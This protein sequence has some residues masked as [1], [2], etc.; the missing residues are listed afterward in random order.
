MDSYTDGM[1][2][3]PLFLGWSNVPFDLSHIL[4]QQDKAFGLSMKLAEENKARAQKVKD[5]KMPDIT[6][7]A[8]S[9]AYDQQALIQARETL[10]S[11]LESSPNPN[12][13]MKNSQAAKDAARVLSNGLDPAAA[14]MRKHQYDSHEGFVEKMKAKG[15]GASAN[16]YMDQNGL[17]VDPYDKSRFLTAGE[18]AYRAANDPNYHREGLGQDFNGAIL[19]TPDDL[20]QKIDNGLKTSAYTE[21]GSQGADF[22][23]LTRLA[24]SSNDPLSQVASAVTLNSK[25]KNNVSQVMAGAK[26]V[27]STLQ[28]PG[29]IASLLNG[30]YATG[31]VQKRMR[32]GEF[33]DKD[34]RVDQNKLTNAM[35][36][37]EVFTASVGNKERKVTYPEKVVLDQVNRHL[38]T[39]NTGSP[40]LVK[41]PNTGNGS[42]SNSGKDFNYWQWIKTA[43]A[44]KQWDPVQEKWRFADGVTER[45]GTFH[46][47]D[48]SGNG[49]STVV[50]AKVQT[51]LMDPNIAH[52]TKLWYGLIK[53]DGTPQDPDKLP[54]ISSLSGNLILTP[55]G[56]PIDVS[57]QRNGKVLEMKNE[58]VLMPAF[59]A[60]PGVQTSPQA[61]ERRGGKYVGT[62]GAA[63]YQVD[64]DQT[65][66]LPF[67]WVRLQVNED[68]PEIKGRVTGGR[69]ASGNPSSELVSIWSEKY[70][71]EHSDNVQ[72]KG[73]W[74]DFGNENS[75]GW[76]L[77]QVD[78]SMETPHTGAFMVDPRLL[79][80]FS[81]PSNDL[82]KNQSLHGAAVGNSMTK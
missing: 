10:A 28:E 52:Q 53:S 61:F 58:V 65:N 41:G 47:A 17:A 54:S 29:N 11:E 78:Q 21:Y 12:W 27:V 22:Q 4:T 31:S 49:Q 66:Q 62:S 51:Q 26:A 81:G 63:A 20:I 60:E 2:K 42:G 33:N 44:S 75:E 79:M 74:I 59:V 57:S 45:E 50:N 32:D 7:L 76:Y 5:Y 25:G 72:N 15:D 24:E 64:G 23:I 13:T 67:V 48:A 30:Y 14:A 8:P 1:N 6:G 18:M 36:G 40:S 3:S 71:A 46:V 43:G 55:D 16:L 77:M 70:R 56:T 19:S 35:F 73:S 68:D 38:S 9:V 82:L 39:S 80:K 37:E 69:T 34:G